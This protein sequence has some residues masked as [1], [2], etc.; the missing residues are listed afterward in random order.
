MKPYTKMTANELHNRLTERNVPMLVMQETEARIAAQRSFERAG[1]SRRRTHSFLWGALVKPLR[2][3]YTSVSSGLSY[4]EST[5]PR[6]AAMLAYKE[7]LGSLL[8]RFSYARAQNTH[9]PSQLAQEIGNLPYGGL[10]W[11]D[12]V[13]PSKKT[14]IA[15][16]FAEIE[17]KPRAKRKIPFERK[18]PVT[19]HA[20]LR[21]RLV[22]SITS[23]M[24]TIAA[25]RARE[26]QLRILPN[27][28]VDASRTRK[29]NR[30][31]YA[32]DKVA[33]MDDTEVLPYT[34]HGLALDYGVEGDPP[35]TGVE[36]ET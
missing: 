7:V 30:L 17:Y 27:K 29:Y 32:R 8:A 6:T 28:S 20:D 14:K 1:R 19:L 12:W 13:P 11:S 22:K 9:T 3:E 31:I 33:A 18:V 24:D 36:D 21:Y 2:N 16:L 25:D 4:P 26:R 34:W 23:E 5:P 35:S 10:H 15:A